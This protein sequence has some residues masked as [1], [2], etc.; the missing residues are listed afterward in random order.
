MDPAP[1]TASSATGRKVGRDLPCV[2]CG[3]QLLGLPESGA[4]PECGGPIARSLHGDLLRFANAGYVRTLN[5]GSACVYWSLVA[6][7]LVEIV[8]IVVLVGVDLRFGSRAGLAVPSF[9]GLGI[10]AAAVSTMAGWWALS[11]PD[12]AR[13][14]T[15]VD[16]STRQ[17]VRFWTA[18]TLAGWVL[19]GVIAV[20]GMATVRRALGPSIGDLAPVL[21]VCGPTIG[22]CFAASRYLGPLAKR[23]ESPALAAAATRMKWCA[24]AAGVLLVAGV[25]LSLV[26]GEP[27]A[28]GLAAVVAV[29]LT[30]LSYTKAVEHARDAIRGAWV[31][32]GQVA[33]GGA[34]DGVPGGAGSSA[35]TAAKIPEATQ[36]RP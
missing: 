29:L 4:C 32:S 17:W 23:A 20:V 6:G 27:A 10:F 14:G 21:L 5:L 15:D 24:V 36:I 22:Q 7:L 18:A 2:R 1:R 31:E 26:T 12:P 19:V 25:G 8:G 30:F 11:T 33:P 16:A 28:N 34:S 13:L 35:S 9:I 3:Y